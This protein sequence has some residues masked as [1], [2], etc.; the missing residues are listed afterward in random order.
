MS[1]KMPFVFVLV[2]IGLCTGLHSEPIPQIQPLRHGDIAD[3][4]PGIEL[5]LYPERVFW[6]E[7]QEPVARA[8]IRNHGPGLYYTDVKYHYWKLSVD[9]KWFEI[10]SNMRPENNLALPPNAWHGDIEIPVS[11][12]W[13]RDKESLK[14]LKPGEHTIQVACFVY[15]DNAEFNSKPVARI[16]SNPVNINILPT[17]GSSPAHGVYFEWDFELDKDVP[18]ILR[19]RHTIA[20]YRVWPKSIS[21]HAKTR[22]GGKGKQG[23]KAILFIDGHAIHNTQ[24]KIRIELLNQAGEVMDAVESIHESSGR[25]QI[26]FGGTARREYKLVFKLGTQGY[27]NLSAVKKFR[28]HFQLAQEEYVLSHAIDRQGWGKLVA[29]LQCRLVPKKVFWKTDHTPK[30]LNAVIRN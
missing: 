4:L 13:T 16:V 9:G 1:R 30:T 5:R 10:I 19:P 26:F 6:Y 18:V 22:S 21:F 12:G 20:A 2:C 27:V 8:G 17:R 23:L 7:G 28:I 29:G 11:K 3:N 15:S 24:W 14:A 25:K